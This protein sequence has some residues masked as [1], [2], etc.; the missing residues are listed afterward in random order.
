M[1]PIYKKCRI[2]FQF[3]AICLISSGIWNSC[4]AQGTIYVSGTYTGK[5]IWNAD[6]VKVTGWVLADTLIIE[7]GTVVEFQTE[8]GLYAQKY[9]FAN[10][11]VGDTIFFTKKDT[12]GFSDP[13]LS[14]GGWG[15]IGG[16]TAK[17][18]Y[19]RIQYVKKF[20]IN[21]SAVN[22]SYL[23][24]M[25]NSCITNNFTNGIYLENS[26]IN[27]SNSLI[28]NNRGLG[29]YGYLGRIYL[30]GCK[31]R[32]N[33]DGGVLS[34]ESGWLYVDNSTI[35]LNGHYGI[36][37]SENYR[38]RINNCR[39]QN[40]N[41]NG[42]EVND[43][44]AIW[45]G[46]VSNNIIQFNNGC[47]F[48][49][50]ICG[51]HFV[52][53]L[54][55]GNSKVGIN[56]GSGFGAGTVYINN[57]IIKNSIGIQL[58]QNH[59]NMYNCICRD[60]GP[61]NIRRVLPEYGALSG[62][63]FNSNIEGINSDEFSGD[64]INNIN[65]DPL[66]GDTS[67]YNFHLKDNSPCINAGRLDTTGLYISSTD[68]DGNPR[69]FDGKIDIGAYEYQQ[70]N[71]HILKQPVGESICQ[72][73]S[74]L[75]ETIAIG[76]ILG[77]QWQKNGS[78]IPS[79]NQDTFAIDTVTLTDSGYYNCI[80]IADDK[81]VST[82]TVILSVPNP[83]PPSSND[84]AICEGQEVPE[85]TAPGDEVTWYSD[86]ELTNAV[87]SGN[88]FNT[89]QSHPGLYV[90]YATQ[91]ISGCES[92][93][94]IITLKIRE[95]PL[96]SLG[97]DSIITTDQSFVLGPYPD[98]YSY[99]WND[100]SQNSG[101]EISGNGL[102]TGSHTITVVVTDTNTCRNSDTL[103]VHVVPITGLDAYQDN[104]L[105][106][107]PNPTHGLLYIQFIDMD[108][109]DLIVKLYNQ[110]GIEVLSNKVRVDQGDKKAELN[111]TLFPRGIYYLQII[112]NHSKYL[113]KAVVQ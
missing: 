27:I 75:F 43:L 19:C 17:L 54:I 55:L 89:G 56:Q 48:T 65:T 111:L 106:V 6:T 104:R 81:T 33:T 13:N 103:M 5:T 12:T 80:I 92:A 91:A 109:E 1:T 46:M 86:A 58:N 22:A 83:E 16:R 18:N 29:I 15:G 108:E 51:I 79:A 24:D 42:I 9:L 11:A 76:G 72:K 28:A 67:I 90:Y 61:Q 49:G 50:S 41:G 73:A 8:Y 102:G 74:A 98:N 39:I 94:G 47:G 69:I 62:N 112:T 10:G 3:L 101:F 95:L 85:L 100:G 93:A 21:G 82:D 84:T 105:D 32:N 2:L 37:S 64:F 36:R 99:L 38:L 88:T 87:H 110:Q 107:F 14:T 57:T 34:R 70:D 31:I 30:F 113:G 71:F 77:Y 68:L 26:K 78:D 35:E 53:N 59:L 20:N 4:L 40:N 97:E 96:I 45:R 25:Q 60:N 7:S 66:F 44:E 52:N 23:L 63:I